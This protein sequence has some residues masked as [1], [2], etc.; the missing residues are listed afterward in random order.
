MRAMGMRW[1]PEKAGLAEED[2]ILAGERDTIFALAD[3]LVS[4]C[5]LTAP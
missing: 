3:G 5:A 1:C 4:K 2:E